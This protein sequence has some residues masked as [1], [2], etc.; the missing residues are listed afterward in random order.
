[1]T[2]LLHPQPVT[3]KALPLALEKTALERYV[4]PEKPSLVG[5]SRAALADALGSVGVPERQ[6]KMR[7][8][9]LWHWIYVRGAQDFDAMTSVSKELR[10]ELAAAFHAGA[11]GG[12]GRAGLGRRHAQMAA[13]AAERTSP[14]SG[15][16][17]S[18]ASTSRRATAARCA[19]R[20]RSAA[21]SP[22]RS[23]TPARSASCA[24]SRRARSSARSWSRATGSATGRAS[25]ARKGPVLPT[26]GDRFVSNI[27]M[28]GMG[29][30]LYNFEAVRDALLVVSD[31]DGL[32]ISRAPH[33]A[34]DLRRRAED[35][36][37]RRRDR[38]HAGDL[39]ARGARRSAQ[40]A[41]AAQPQISDSPN[42]ST[43]AATIRASRM[44]GASPSNM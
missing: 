24:I 3:S 6:R 32:G 26:E 29:E 40:R 28:M 18:S 8:Q 12:R 37:R 5:L 17:R 22:A 9:Q 4:A 19:C 43:P 27:V 15:R 1:M 31:G 36:A 34:L 38:H 23:A 35:R 39:A 10:A 25:T 44:R 41:G 16:T 2:T 42:C 21:R 13:A 14:A 11:A 7:V 20:A 30:P 33:H